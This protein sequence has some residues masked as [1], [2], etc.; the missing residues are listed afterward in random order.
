MFYFY[1]NKIQSMIEMKKNRIVSKL[2]YIV[3]AIIIVF[4][5]TII[6]LLVIKKNDNKQRNILLDNACIVSAAIDIDGL[7]SLTAGKSDLNSPFYQHLKKQL[8]KIRASNDSY[9]F[10][11]LLGIKEGKETVSF[12]IDSQLPGSPDY[13]SPGEIYSE[14]PG[15][16]I[17]SA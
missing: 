12:F 8:F 9:K 6:S 4:V 17:G 2:K 15:E 5:L 7:K 13:A 10:L 16:Y 14:V 3:F 11:Y 1:R